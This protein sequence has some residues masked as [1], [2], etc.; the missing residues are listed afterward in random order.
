M[1]N[2]GTCYAAPSHL[3][4][5]SY[6]SSLV[7]GAEVNEGDEES[8]CPPEWPVP[9]SQGRK[10]RMSAISCGRLIGG[11]ARQT[12]THGEFLGCSEREFWSKNCVWIESLP[13]DL[14]FSC[15]RNTKKKEE[16]KLQLI[17]VIN[18]FPT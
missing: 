12:G 10:S 7:S 17:T 3:P 2:Y 9:G 15:S 6:L 18:L 11:Q 14:C 1:S 5:S 13:C 16:K 8:R 4:F